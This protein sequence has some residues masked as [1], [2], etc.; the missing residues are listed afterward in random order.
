MRS[1]SFSYAAPDTLADA[2]ALLGQAGH[3]VLP[4]GTALAS[5]QPAAEATEH[6][7]VSLR[8]VADLRQITA[9]PE[10]VAIGT[11]ASYTA[12]L[13][14]PALQQL[15]A[16]A[17][18][19]ATVPD[20]HLRHHST[21]GGAL[22]HGGPCHAPVLAALLALGA[23]VRV[24][25]A[26]GQVDELPLPTLLAEPASQRLAGKV[27]THVLVPTEPALHSQYLAFEQ[28]LGYYASQG[29]AVA[30][31]LANNQLTAVRVALAGFTAQ[32]Q[33]LP[34]VEAALQNQQP[35]PATLATAAAQLDAELTLPGP[36]EDEARYHQHLAKVLLRRCL[37]A[38]FA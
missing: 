38:A 20:A 14:A 13:Q 35:L 19:L 3:Q 5:Y 12:L 11:S 9:E 22:H 17:Q 28:P 21:L 1:S 30:G 10:H 16:L 36:S 2:L 29:V 7:L 8:R 34:G 33:R 27:A 31:H 32:P 15:S 25:S 6:T 26:T 4:L 24:A 18:A 23:T 37:M